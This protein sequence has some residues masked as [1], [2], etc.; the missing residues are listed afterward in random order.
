VISNEELWRRAEGTEISVQIRRRKFNL[1]G[2]ILRKG[3]DSVEREALDLNPQGHRKSGRP[4][5]TW[6]R[7]VHKEAL[8]EGKNWGEVRKVARIRIRWRLLLTPYDPKEG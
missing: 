5:E 4:K 7:S 2:H 6:R 1:I 3:N 8:E